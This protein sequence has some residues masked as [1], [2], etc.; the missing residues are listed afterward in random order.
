MQD[1]VR[2][3]TLTAMAEGDADEPQ[4]KKM[5]RSFQVPSFM[6]MIIT[7]ADS[8]ICRASHRISLHTRGILKDWSTFSKKWGQFSSGCNAWTKIS[9]KICMT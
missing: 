2:L 5:Q 6:V 3:Q 7:K 9:T 1:L 8:V 4:K